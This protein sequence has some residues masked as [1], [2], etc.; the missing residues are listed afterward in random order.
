MDQEVKFVGTMVRKIYDSEDFKIYAMDVDKATYPDIKFNKYKNTSITGELPELS[1]GMSYEITAVEQQ[2]K[3]GYSYKVMNIRQDKLRNSYDMYLFLQEIL[4]ANQAEQLWQHYPDI[5]QRVKENHLEDIDLNKLK[6]IGEYTFNLIVNKIIENY[7]LADLV[8]E[9]QGYFSL[10]ILKKLYTRYSSVE[11]LKQK[12]QQKP[13]ACLTALA[14]IGFKTAD[15]LLLDLEA[16]SKKNIDEGKQ[17]IIE[18]EDD[19]CTSFQRCVACVVYLL[20]ENEENGHTKMS[21]V[22]LREAV[23]K[24]VPAC[25]D[26]F[27]EAIKHKW[28]YYDKDSLDVALKWTY[29]T[30]KYIA[31]TII[32]TLKSEQIVWKFDI[33]KYRDI[34]DISLS[35]EQMN[36]IRNVC[37]YNISILNGAAGCVDCDTEYFNGREWKRIADYNEEDKVLQ[38]NEDGTAELVYP[39]NYIKQKADYLWHFE[40]KY[41]LDQCL[42]DNHTCYYITSKGN[43]YSKPFKE[44]RENQNT[45]GF[46]GKFITTFEYKGQGVNLTDDEIR[47]MIATFADGSFYYRINCSDDTYTKARFHL[48]KARKK[49]RLIEIIKRLGYEYR[50]F[51]SSAK[52]YDDVYVNVPFRCKHFPKDWYNCNQH[53]LQI[54]ADEINYWDSYYQKQNNFSTTNKSDADFIQFVFTSLGY[55]TTISVNDRTNQTYLTN[56]KEYQRKS[57][58]YTVSHTKRN[59]ITMDWDHRRWDNRTKITKY[60]TKDGYEYCFTVPSHMLVLRRNNKIFITGNCGKTQSTSSIIRLLDDNNISYKLFAPTGRASKILKSF[61]NRPASTIHRGLGYMP[62]NNWRI[63]KDNPLHTD[64]VIV[65]EFSMVDV[66]LFRHLI[67]AIDF[68]HTKLFLIGDSSQLPSVGCGNLLHDFMMPKIVPTTTL[69]KVFRY[70]EGGLMKIATDVRMCK[71]YLT[72]DNKN[73]MTAFGNNK[74]YIYIDMPSE[75]IPKYAVSLYKKLL[76]NGCSIEDIQVLSAKNVSE[77]GSNQLNNML[78]KVANPKYMKSKSLTMSDVSYYEGDLIIQ[79]VNNYRAEIAKGYPQSKPDEVYKDSKTGKDVMFI[80]NGETGIVDTVDDTSM[81]IDFDGMYVRYSKAELK[82][83]KLGYCISVHRSQGGSCENIIVCTPQSH[84]FML[85]NNLIYTALTR[86]KKRCYHLGTLQT[87]NRAVMKKANFQRN[88]FMQQ[89]LKEGVSDGRQEEKEEQ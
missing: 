18:F 7:C 19:L 34:G 67:E 74:D 70:G 29:D 59:L 14:G 11:V 30:E 52:G 22:D 51:E 57:I 33:D 28:I 64:I 27:V 25:A 86:M 16:L 10:P 69:T 71:P 13:Y 61:T 40:T 72:K 46:K 54:I 20:Q 32:S 78:Q 42:S 82:M 55:R 81:V 79:T 89:L 2:T 6:G 58:E 49:D 66:D 37:K 9:F 84:T 35:D 50:I 24:L 63:N 87:V 48:K 41:G 38:Y 44:I 53:Q 68:K 88:T 47:L 17:P 45:T 23:L 36:A 15:T 4:T 12:L 80:A 8:V 39:L 76:N 73:Q 5:V 31:E 43:L 62:V 26:H 60:N 56:G 3:Y 1:E 83:I 77:C 65:D 75:K 21:L 85:N